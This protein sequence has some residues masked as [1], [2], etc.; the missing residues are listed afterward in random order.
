MFTVWSAEDI[1]Y[2][3]C[4]ILEYCNVF[5]F[6][7]Y[8]QKCPLKNFNKSTKVGSVLMD[9]SS[10]NDQQMFTVHSR[11]TNSCVSKEPVR[12]TRCV[13]LG[14]PFLEINNGKWQPFLAAATPAPLL[15]ARC[16]TRQK[17]KM[18]AKCVSVFVVMCSCTTWELQMSGAIFMVSVWGFLN[19]KWT[20]PSFQ[21]RIKGG[22][23]CLWLYSW[24]FIQL[25]CSYMA[26]QLDTTSISHRKWEPCRLSF[27]NNQKKLLQ[28]MFG[29]A[30]LRC[31]Y[32]C[33]CWKTIFCS[34]TLHPEANNWFQ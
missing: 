7:Q 29:V 34:P 17:M 21:D 33:R 20:K 16:R 30:F 2:Q 5:S 4:T 32:H 6:M 11:A 25:S 15:R 14:R 27:C 31:D 19:V 28:D 26:T 1:L 10:R 18:K 3:D 12:I 24:C 9:K 22:S 23:V 8:M 13:I